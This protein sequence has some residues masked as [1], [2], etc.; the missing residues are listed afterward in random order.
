MDL[1]VGS[2]GGIHTAIVRAT[3]RCRRIGWD[4]GNDPGVEESNVR[5]P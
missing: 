4:F 1:V 5:Y 3:C 2:S